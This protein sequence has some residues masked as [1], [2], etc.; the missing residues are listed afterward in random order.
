M[1][2][3]RGHQDHVLVFFVI[4]HLTLIS[5]EDGLYCPLQIRH[6]DLDLDLEHLYV[7]GRVREPSL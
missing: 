7:I 4:L 6:L 3:L 1:D 5:A 2:H